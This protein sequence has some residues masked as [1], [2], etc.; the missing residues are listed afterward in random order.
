MLGFG[1]VG[2]FCLSEWEED[3]AFTHDRIVYVAAEARSNIVGSEN[4]SAIAS[5]V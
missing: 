1:C 3:S 5:D 2:E 4:R